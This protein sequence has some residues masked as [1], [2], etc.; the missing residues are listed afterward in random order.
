MTDSRF[1]D[2]PLPDPLPRAFYL[3]DTLDVAKDLLGR[4][5]IHVRPE[6]VSSGIIVEAEAYIGPDDA[7]A[8]S[9]GGIR[10]PRT[11]A[12][13]AVGGTAY[14]FL[15]YG[16]HVCFNVVTGG[17]DRPEAVLIRALEPRRG[18]ALMA[19]RRG[20]KIRGKALSNGPGKLCRALGIG[21]E[22]YGDD[23]CGGRLFLS[24]GDGPLSA[25]RRVASRRVNI[26][27]AGEAR[28]YP[29]RFYIDGNPFVSVK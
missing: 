6:G 4:E 25:E 26:D 10:T 27:Y 18:L 29:W 9:R 28:E 20:E 13:Y 2:L 17:V 15:V 14:T 12:M 11:E 22:N 24:N 8:H 1:S 7:A 5:L 16:M 21:M 23:L 3:R 19:R